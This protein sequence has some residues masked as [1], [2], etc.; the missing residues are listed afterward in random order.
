MSYGSE[1]REQLI[2]EGKRRSEEQ[3]FYCKHKSEGYIEGEGTGS[4]KSER[5]K[6]GEEK[7]FVIDL[8]TPGQ[9]SLDQFQ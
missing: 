4:S 8:D 5:S 6:G 1:P 2:E 7:I 3:K 9:A